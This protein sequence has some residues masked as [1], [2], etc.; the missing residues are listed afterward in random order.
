MKVSL[1]LVLSVALIEVKARWLFSEKKQK[2]G[3][4]VSAETEAQAKQM[5]RF[6]ALL[7][8]NLKRHPSTDSIGMESTS[9][10]DD[11]WQ[12]LY[13]TEEP[14]ETLVAAKDL[15]PET[16]E[17]KRARFNEE[18]AQLAFKKWYFNTET[19]TPPSNPSFLS[20]TGDLNWSTTPTGYM[21]D[22][23]QGDLISA[24]VRT[25]PLTRNQRRRLERHKRNREM[26]AAK[27]WEEHVAT[28]KSVQSEDK[29]EEHES[30]QS[31]DKP[32][33]PKNLVDWAQGVDPKAL[34]ELAS[35][36]AQLDVQDE[37]VD[38]T[39]DEEHDSSDDEGN[40]DD[41]PSPAFFLRE[42]DAFRGLKLRAEDWDQ[43][44]DLMRSQEVQQPEVQQPIV[45][46]PKDHDQG[47]DLVDTMAELAISEP[48]EDQTSSSDSSE[49]SIS[50]NAPPTISRSKKRRERR[51]HG[52]ERRKAKKF[53]HNKGPLRPLTIP[54]FFE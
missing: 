3:A 43:L 39:E 17:E 8:K 42:F 27:I 24:P 14:S 52:Q 15:Q 38:A 46:Q 41:N 2:V 35:S 53:S 25:K 47:D 32:E 4:S 51:K 22:S 26:A 44:A 31:E 19:P 36:L 37:V 48:S 16:A 40:S 9:D 11:E 7:A 10:E 49:E 50:S 28:L 33:E 18:P 1:A 54:N 12:E 29:P 20:V 5:A 13:S 45:Q 23:V 6:Q 30:V 34:E 21:G